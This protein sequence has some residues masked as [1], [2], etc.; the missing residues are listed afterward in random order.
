MKTPQQ[1]ADPNHRCRNAGISPRFAALNH[2]M[3]RESF[4]A[5]QARAA[6]IVSQ[7]QVDFPQATIELDYQTPLELLVAVLLSA[8]TTDKRVNLVTPKLFAQFVEATDYAAAVPG[9]IEPYIQSV[10]LF[11]SKAKHLV[12]LGKALTEKYQGH[13]PL[14]RHLLAELPGVGQKTAGVV[15]MHLGGTTAFPVDTHVL[16]LANRMGLSTATRPDDVEKDLQK[17]VAEPLWFRGHQVFIWHGRRVC[18]ARTPDCSNCSIA[19]W[20]AQRNVVVG[21]SSKS[22]M[23][24]G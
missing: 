23:R 14:Q 7:L 11:R 2:T 15:S 22:A 4:H 17:L 21:K 19:Q 16:R 12:A 9:D 1:T 6:K 13:V 20:C 24:L 8:Q 3:A 10:G 5:R 18:H